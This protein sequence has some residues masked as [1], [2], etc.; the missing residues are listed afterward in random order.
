MQ[1]PNT[2]RLFM[3]IAFA[4]ILLAP[5]S[6]QSSGNRPVGDGHLRLYSYH[7][8]EYIDVKFRND[9]GYIEDALVKIDG[10]FRSRDSNIYKIDRKL[11]DLLDHIQ[12]HFGA[13]T[14]EIISG[15]RSSKYNSLLRNLGRGAAGESLHM[16]GMAADIHIDEVTESDLFEYVKSL[17]AGGAGH[18]PRYD[19]VHVDTGP[20]RVWGEADAK[21]RV[22]V[23]TENNPNI[24]WS[25]I[26]DKNI[27]R[28]GD[29]IHAKISNNEY[30]K[31][32]P[33]LKSVWLER[34]RKGAW[35]E[36]EKVK[37]DGKSKTLHTGE[38]I[39]ISRQIHP[40]RAYGK[41]RLVIFPCKKCAPTYSNEF[42][43]K[44]QVED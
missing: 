37:V 28:D 22:F 1:P 13:E 43:I 7:L 38:F 44:K 30:S 16:K 15:Y 21:K 27:Y 6:S 35:S 4:A 19:F 18:Y 34:F 17:G 40:G 26:T 31:R 39:K 9:K 29:I 3:L 8:N 12:D 33:S 11:I 24:G 41:Y 2:I 23:G 42:Y 10:V 20:I 14:I 32:S 25:T 36:H 5:A